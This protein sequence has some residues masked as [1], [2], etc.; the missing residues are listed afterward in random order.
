[1]DVDEGEYGE[2]NAV[3]CIC[4]PKQ[5]TFGRVSGDPVVVVELVFRV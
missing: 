2:T 1:M 5:P 4:L 3:S